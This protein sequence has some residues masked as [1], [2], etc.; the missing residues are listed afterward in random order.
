LS[1]IGSIK[2]EILPISEIVEWAY[3]FLTLNYLNQINARFNLKS[4]LNFQ[5]FIKFT[6]EKYKFV[7]KDLQFDTNRAN[8]FLFNEL[9]NG[10]IV[11]VNYEK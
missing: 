2:K 4:S 9:V 11:K 7:R 8:E 10:N 3:K 1:L 5:D 6:C